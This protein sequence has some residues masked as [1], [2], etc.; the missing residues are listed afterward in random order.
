MDALSG[1]VA[2]TLMEHVRRKLMKLADSAFEELDL[3]RDVDLRVDGSKMKDNPPRV[4][5]K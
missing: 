3:S 2:A 1:A 4:I 5:E